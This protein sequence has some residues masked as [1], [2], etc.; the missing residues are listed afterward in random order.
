MI[1]TYG[2][3]NAAKTTYGHERGP[4]RV[5]VRSTRPLLL[6]ASSYEPVDWQIE[7]APG[8]RLVGVVALGYYMPVV[9]G[10]IAGARIVTNELD[11][12]CDAL[13][14]GPAYAY[15]PGEKQQELADTVGRMLGAEVEDFQSGPAAEFVIE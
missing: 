14:T 7:L 6:V 5:K 1:G 13:K 4:I 11:E 3:P 10:R 15:E 12:R 2:S 8:A 9:S